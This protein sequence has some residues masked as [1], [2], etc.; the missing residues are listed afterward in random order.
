MSRPTVMLV[1]SLQDDREMYAEYLRASAF[2]VL[3]IDHAADALAHAVRADVV[4]TDVR[5][6]GP[7]DGLELI[8]QL[9]ADDDTTHTPIL[10]LTACAFGV[11]RERAERAGCDAFLPKP[12][13]PHVLLAEI[14]RVLRGPLAAA[15]AP[16]ATGSRTRHPIEGSDASSGSGMSRHGDRDRDDRALKVVEVSQ[17]R[18]RR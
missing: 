6:D 12:C 3:E 2:T 4:V 11:D 1:A 7:S 18:R 8:R 5:V 16:D 9:R 10:V 14:R 13:L 17:K 15:R